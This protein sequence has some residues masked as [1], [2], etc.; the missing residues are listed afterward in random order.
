MVGKPPHCFVMG[1]EGLGHASPPSNGTSTVLFSLSTL[2]PLLKSRLIVLIGDLRN[3][4]SR[5]RFLYRL[6]LCYDERILALFLLNDAR[7]VGNLLLWTT[8]T[9]LQRVD[10]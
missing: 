9:K 6:L 1:I 2:S 10:V 5:F 8:A 3:G 4:L 7:H